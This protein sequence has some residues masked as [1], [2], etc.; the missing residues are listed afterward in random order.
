M[1]VG[2]WMRVC[3]VAAGIR[4]SRSKEKQ[5]RC[6]ANLNVARLIYGAQCQTLTRIGQRFCSF[7]EPYAVLQCTGSG[8]YDGRLCRRHRAVRKNDYSKKQKLKHSTNEK[9]IE[10][11][12][13]F[14]FMFQWIGHVA[15]KIDGREGIPYRLMSIFFD[16]II[17]VEQIQCFPNETY[18]YERKTLCMVR[19]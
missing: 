4:C 5:Y 9:W 17:N 13:T 8:L 14:G 7:N 15:L 3:F 16:K 19:T 12:A 1:N 2:D 11:F 6:E 18:R 10:C